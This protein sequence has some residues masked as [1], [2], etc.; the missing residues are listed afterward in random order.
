ML[1][2]ATPYRPI[3]KSLPFLEYVTPHDS[4]GRILLTMLFGIQ[5]LLERLAECGNAK[6]NQ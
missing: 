2:Y 1:P 4:S 6:E 5:Y 3:Q